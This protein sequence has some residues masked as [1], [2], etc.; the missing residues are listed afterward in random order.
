MKRWVW[1][2][3]FVITVGVSLLGWT[4]H[5]GRSL[6]QGQAAHSEQASVT[7]PTNIIAPTIDPQRLLADVEALSFQRYDQLSRD[8]ARG[9][10][11][12]ALQSAGW[13]PQTQSFADEGKDGINIYAKR[14]GTDA[15]AGTLLLA[16]HYDTVEQSPGADDNATSVA[17]ILEAA[18]LLG[19]QS[20]PRSLQIVLFD[21][22]ETG[23]LGS[24]AFAADVDAEDLRGAIIMDMI[25]YA[26]YIEG[27]QS[28]P[29]LPIKPPT[30][31]GDFLAIIGDQAH[32]FLIDSFVQAR[33]P[34]QPQVF[35]LA[36]PTFGRLTPDLVRSDHVPFWRRGIA[37]VLVT[38][39][40]N[41][42][43]PNYHQP[44]DTPNNLDQEFFLGAA[45]LVVN[46]TAALL[47]N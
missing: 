25:G 28:Y 8:R 5:Q 3:L 15:A 16:A 31:R 34:E 23:L 6:L 39:T 47:E 43:N 17:T 24:K 33:Q 45:Q 20:T 22:E 36:I 10:I 26:C 42:R 30:D 2:L 1:L 44:T 12:Q 21:Q 19:Q 4:Q 7:G 32:P 18:R 11:A 38:D 35:S 29:P 13:V 14:P 40:A 46:A 9:Y 27:C 37:A 41:F